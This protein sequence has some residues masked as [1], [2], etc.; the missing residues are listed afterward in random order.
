MTSL[1][2]S[3]IDARD[4]IRGTGSRRSDASDKKRGMLMLSG[5]RLIRWT[6]VCAIVSAA[7]CS[8]APDAAESNAGALGAPR[9]NAVRD[10]LL[11]GNSV[12][13]TVSFLDGHTFQSLGS[14]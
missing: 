14:F 13:G 10:V 2:G 7:G 9:T 11:V 12:A 4:F 8:T 1:I 3:P 6:C 5:E